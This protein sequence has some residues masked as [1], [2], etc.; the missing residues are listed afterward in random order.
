MSFELPAH[1]EALRA[2][3]QDGLAE[4][5]PLSGAEL[6][7]L[8][9]QL[10]EGLRPF[11]S[12]QL[13]VDSYR[14]AR[15]AV[16]PASRGSQPF[17]WTTRVAQRSLGLRALRAM[18]PPCRLGV[19]DAAE[20]AIDEAIGDDYS[21]GRWLASQDGPA[22]GA[23]VGAVATWASR[24]WVAVPWGRIGTVSLMSAALRFR[25]FGLGGQVTLEARPD[26]VIQ[27]GGGRRDDPRQVL[28][29]LG[30]ASRIAIGLEALVFALVRGVAPTR[31]VTVQPSLGLVGSVEVDGPLLS[32]AV[33]GVVDAAPVLAA[34]PDEAVPLEEAVPLDEVPGPQCWHCSRRHECPTGASW[35]RHQSRRIGGIPTGEQGTVA[36]IAR[37]GATNIASSG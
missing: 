36:R 30:P 16:C 18:T 19:L 17:A 26:A 27:P 2:A 11:A 34:A 4:E 13:L 37:I 23:T 14:L 31:V 32:A 21:V 22:R 25:P 20:S 5:P 24:A 29:R 28:L 8:R 15:V 33:E 1:Q 9:V 10:V 6:A 35:L 3:V 12:T 7:A